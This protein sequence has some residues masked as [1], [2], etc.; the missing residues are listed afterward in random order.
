MKGII[1]LLFTFSLLFPNYHP[2]KKAIEEIAKVKGNYKVLV[3]FG[4]WCKDSQLHVPQF[5]K[6]IWEAQN[7]DISYELLPLPR[8]RKHPLRT[9]YN[10]ERVPTFIIYRNNEEIGRIIEHPKKSIEEDLAE[11][12]TGRGP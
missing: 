6:V 4:Y 12:L 1:P 7:P 9:K 5:I 11:I 2:K 10:I 8:T 3:V